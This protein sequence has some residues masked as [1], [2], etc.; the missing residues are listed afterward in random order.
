MSETESTA[1][2]IYG[3]IVG[4]AVMVASHERTATAVATAVLVTLV[5]YWAAER[6]SRLVA[7][8]IHEG[9]PPSWREV[10]RQLAAGW[11]M[12]TASALPL[13]V[14]LVL[15]LSGVDLS[16]AVFGALLCST[17]VLGL[18]GWRIGRDGRLRTPERIVSAVVAGAFGVLM[19]LAK[20]MLH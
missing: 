17:A 11:E 6:Y 9:H 2:G 5:V 10:R 8:R 14:L 3:V 20:T 18:A 19:I 1:A 7:E 4:A 13:A 15:R 16:A 12:V